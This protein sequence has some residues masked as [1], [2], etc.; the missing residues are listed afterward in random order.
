M[1]VIIKIHD[2][3][4]RTKEAFVAKSLLSARSFI[5]KDVDLTSEEIKDYKIPSEEVVSPNCIVYDFDGL[6]YRIHYSAKE[7]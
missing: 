4:D 5:C 1:I 6:V 2:D 7:I 3:I